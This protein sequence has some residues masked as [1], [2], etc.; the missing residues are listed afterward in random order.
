MVTPGAA[1]ARGLSEP[2]TLSQAHPTTTTF[3]HPIL[4]NAYSMLGLL[5][6]AGGPST[7]GQTCPL[8]SRTCPLCISQS[9]GRLC[10]QAATTCPVSPPHGAS[11]ACLWKALF[12]PPHQVPQGGDYILF[13]TLP[14]TVPN[15]GPC[16]AQVLNIW[17][18]GLRHRGWLEVG[19][20]GSV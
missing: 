7:Q 17:M 14:L 5:P 15:R 1:L 6:S 2:P 20:L 3:T 16:A 13:M 9:P 12:C 11:R 8:P 18:E 10:T 19:H 4:M